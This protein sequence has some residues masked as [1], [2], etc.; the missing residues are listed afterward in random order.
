MKLAVSAGSERG[1]VQIGHYETA[2]C[3]LRLNKLPAGGVTG[4][5]VRVSQLAQSVKKKL[6]EKMT[7]GAAAA[8]I[9]PTTTRSSS[10]SSN[11]C[12]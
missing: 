7:S 4:A 5:R 1:G 12:K 10:S 3:H 8:A 6:K 9:K 2:S 11:V